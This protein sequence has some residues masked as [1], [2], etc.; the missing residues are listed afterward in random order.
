MSRKQPPKYS[1]HKGSGQARV[2][3]NGKDIYLG[4]YGSKASREEYA[5]ILSKWLGSQDDSTSLTSLS[6]EQLALAFLDHAKARYVKDGESTDHIY[7]V[8]SGLRLL[9]EHHRGEPAAEFS[10]RK[11]KQ[12]QRVLAARDLSRSYINDL[13]SVIKRCFKW[14]VSEELLTP[15]V[16]EGLRSV[17]AVK[18]GQTGVREPKSVKPVID[19]ET[20]AVFP[21]VSSQIKAM[22]QLQQ[23]TGMRPG[24]VLIMRPCDVTMT[25]EGVW[26]YRPE[27]HKTEHHGKE[28]VVFL[29]EKAQTILRPWLDRDPESYCFQPAESDRSKNRS[30]KDNKPYRRD[31]YALA[32]RRACKKIGFTPWSPN[33]LRHTYATRVREQFGLEAAQVSL[34][35]SRADVTQVYAERNEKLGADV[36]RM[37][38]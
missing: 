23:L 6:V 13:I 36:A 33:Q 24:E 3:L 22:I 2:R 29:G 4:V 37:I 18:R 7:M 1:L 17:D 21:H 26:K 12:L 30:M 10:P 28:R 32:I 8:R 5:R 11:L 20:E 35:H 38:G 31:S 25:T 19:T 27:S 14:G 9:L 34:G 16:F 15:Q